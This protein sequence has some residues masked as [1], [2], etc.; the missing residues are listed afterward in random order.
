LDYEEMVCCTQLWSSVVELHGF[1]QDSKPS[2]FDP[3]L[4]R[5]NTSLLSGSETGYEIPVMHIHLQAVL[6][7]GDL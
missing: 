3:R 5:Y 6:V 2:E 1:L 4:H 7:F